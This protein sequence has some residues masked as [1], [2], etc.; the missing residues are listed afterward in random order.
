MNNCKIWK[1]AFG[2]VLVGIIIAIIFTLTNTYSWYQN[3]GEGQGEVIAASKEDIIA[4]MEIYYEKDMPILRLEKGTGIDYSPIVFFSIEGEAKDYVLHMNSARLEGAVDIPIIPNVNLPQALSLILSWEKEVVG[5]LRVKHLNEFIDD[6][7]E[8]RL[9]KDYLLSRYFC[10]RGLETYGKN[11]LSSKE[12][13]QLIDLLKDS[14][15]YAGDYLEWNEVEWEEEDNWIS[16]VYISK[17]QIPLID[18]IAPNLLEYNERL[19]E[20]FEIVFYDLINE[21][22]KNKALVKENEEL[23]FRIDELERERDEL[24]DYIS[25]LEAEIQELID[26]LSRVPVCKPE[27]PGEPKESDSTPESEL[28]DSEEPEPMPEPGEAESEEAESTPEVPN[29][30]PSLDE[31]ETGL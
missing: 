23:I 15:L 17:D 20:V 3:G 21:I 10:D 26:R 16:G 12:K 24:Y 22:E 7:L 1:K 13:N 2:F 27:N 18:I 5:N 29:P 4:N 9:S 28:P 11:Y 30:D 14:L 25:G 31:P 19:Y 8:V 6:S